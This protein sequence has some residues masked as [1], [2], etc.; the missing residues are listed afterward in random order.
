MIATLRFC[1]GT[2]GITIAPLLDSMQR[3]QFILIFSPLIWV[4]FAFLMD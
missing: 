4:E 1:R 2:V 3:A